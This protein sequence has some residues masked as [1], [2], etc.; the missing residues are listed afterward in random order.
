VAK[1]N[2]VQSA[3]RLGQTSKVNGAEKQS[4]LIPGF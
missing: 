1:E 2:D 4:E 3:I